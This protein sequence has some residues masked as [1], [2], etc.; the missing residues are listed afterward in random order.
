MRPP[1][2]YNIPAHV[3]FTDA[4][5]AG[6]LARFGGDPVQLARVHVFLPNRR[7]VRSLTDAFVR[8]SADGGL[9][10]PRMTPVGDLG[11]DSF[12]RYAS[13]DAP[14][15]RPITPLRRRL[16]LARLVRAFAARARQQRGAVEALRLADELGATLDALTAEEIDPARL[17][18]EAVDADLAEHW[19]PTLAFL[20]III[21]EWP[22]ICA[23]EGTG[24][25]G[26]RLA[27]LID[28]MVGRWAAAHPGPVVAAGILA[29][30]PPVGRLLAAVARLD[31]GMVVLPGLDTGLSEAGWAS[32]CCRLAED[33]TDD[34]PRRRDSEEHPQFALKCLLARLGVERAAVRDWG[35]T[36][37]LDGPAKR[38]AQV[39]AAMGNDA[40]SAG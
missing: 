19:Q 21:A 20:D 6:L 9:L 29:S 2:V 31:G 14:V 37:G 1:E 15:A 33:E 30:S 12:E 36:T 27:A 10:L 3:A 7:A 28:A 18:A 39:A 13:G 8:A 40:G 23:A 17:T 24:E 11:D 22:R 35:V 25:G 16:E 26:T 32:I 4:L 34:A 38:T 5:A